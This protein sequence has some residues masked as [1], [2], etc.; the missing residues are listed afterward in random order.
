MFFLI[1]FII[2]NPACYEAIIL[3]IKV[4][5]TKVSPYIRDTTKEGS[6]EGPITARIKPIILKNE[7]KFR[8]MMPPRSN[9]LSESFFEKALTA[10]VFEQSFR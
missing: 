9:P 5:A 6:I 3:I 2:K 8:F 7:F 4:F 1:L 10:L